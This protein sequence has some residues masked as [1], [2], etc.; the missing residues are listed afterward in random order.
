[1]DKHQEY[2]AE[3]DG[4]VYPSDYV[5]EPCLVYMARTMELRNFVS[6][7]FSAIK[8]IQA[9]T[10]DRDETSSDSVA[11]Y[12]FSEHRQLLNQVMLS[13]AIESFNLYLTTSLRNIFLCKPEILKSD[14][15]IEISTIIEAGDYE[16]LVWRIAEKKILELSYKP[17][18]ELKK[19]IQERTGIDIFPDKQSFDTILM[20]SEIR[21]LIAHNDCIKSE[22][23][24]KRTKDIHL[25]L[26]VSSSDRI[27]ISDAWLRTASYTIDKSVFHFD[28][29]AL[30]KFD[31]TKFNRMSSF[32][33]RG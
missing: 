22:L 1:M 12:N 10:K 25:P 3:T 26:E 18:K 23:F 30:Q 28:S 6:A 15:M 7:F 8:E 27:M 2:G 4:F 9:I 13:R 11:K 31:L 32:I 14:G 29:S 19:Y 33:F 24:E 17:M 21:N 5:T 16:E 20:A